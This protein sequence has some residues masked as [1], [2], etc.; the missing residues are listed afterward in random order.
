MDF[1]GAKSDGGGGDNWSSKHANF[2]AV[3]QYKESIHQYGYKLTTDYS[4]V[5]QI[6][7]LSNSYAI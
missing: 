5:D 7:R 3:V 1:I 6:I 2:T 4:I